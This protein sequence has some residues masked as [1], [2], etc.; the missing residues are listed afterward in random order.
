M[1]SVEGNVSGDSAGKA[2]VLGL[3]IPGRDKTGAFRGR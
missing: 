3:R 2:A 1:T